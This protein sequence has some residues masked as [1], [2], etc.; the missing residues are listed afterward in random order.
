MRK[1]II[2]IAAFLGLAGMGVVDAE[3]AEKKL[4]SPYHIVTTCTMVTDLVANIAGDKAKVTGLMGEGVDPHLY[5]P[6]RDDLATLSKADVIF[7]SGLMLEGRMA[8]TFAKMGRSQIPAYAVTELLDDEYLLEPEDFEGHWDPHVWNDVKAWI[9]ATKAVAG[10]LSEI[11]ADNADTYEANC[12]AYVA[13][14]EKV[15]A[16]A[17]KSIATIPEKSRVLITAHDAF[18]YFARAYGI[19]V[20]AAQGVT[21]ES[22]AAVSDI[23]ELVDF[24]VENGI[25]NIF[26]ENIVSDRNL[27][28]VVEG[29]KAKGH[30]LAIGGE[31][32]SD[33]T[34]PAG[35]YEGT[36]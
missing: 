21:T 9:S 8:D 22:E 13:E 26:V 5:K 31:L 32:Y 19:K 1:S 11:D 25:N 34:G 24:V 30:D 36:Y 12:E 14:L 23:N 35:T 15:D 6:T 7:Y 4:D 20:M 17:K 33:A 27:Q 18:N 16:Y 29:A 3:A 28:A 2:A 10:A